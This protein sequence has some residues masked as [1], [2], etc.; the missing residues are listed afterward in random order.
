MRRKYWRYM[1]KKGHIKPPGTVNYG[2]IFQEQWDRAMEMYPAFIFLTG[3]NEWG[4]W[5]TK[6]L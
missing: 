4:S 6:I 1:H 5:K 3:W 2:Y